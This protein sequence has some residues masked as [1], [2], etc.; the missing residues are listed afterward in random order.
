MTNGQFPPIYQNCSEL[1]ADNLLPFHKSAQYDQRI[2]SSC[3]LKVLRMTSTVVVGYK[4]V[5]KQIEP[6]TAQY[7][8]I[9][10]WLVLDL[11]FNN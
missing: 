11:Y 2:I 6:G 7:S 5:G 9:T 4:L 8:S 3:F 10:F 1:P